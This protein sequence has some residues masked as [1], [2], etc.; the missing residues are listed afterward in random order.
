MRSLLLL[1]CF[2]SAAASAQTA[3]AQTAYVGGRWFTGDGFEA[4]DT[5]WA[6]RGTFVAGRRAGRVV[7]LGDLFVVPPF[8][9]GHLHAFESLETL[10]DED[11]LFV[12]RGVLYVLNPHVPATE[13]ASVRGLR[14]TVDV[15]YAVAGVTAPGAHPATAYEA[16]ALGLQPWD[17]WGPRGPEIRASRLRDGDA[18]TS[19]ATLADL[20]A[21]WPRVLA[22]GTDWVKVILDHSD[23]WDAGPPAQPRGLDPA[24]AAEV[25][26]RA[27]AAGLRVAAHV[28]TAADLD[29]ALDAGADLLAHVPGFSVNDA[30]PARADGGALVLSDAHLARLARVPAAPTLARGPAMVR[31]IPEASRPDA[32][33][34]DAVRAF[35]ADLLRR[36]VAAGVPLIVGADSGGLWAWDEAAYWVERG[37]APLDVLRA[38]AVTT[39][40]AIFP[41]RALGR[42]APGAEAS[43]LALA[44]DPLADWTC[45][46]RI[47][48]R[49]VQGERLP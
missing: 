22:S 28:V 19:A 32:A 17:V 48:A 6:E 21:A 5:T 12:A 49:V 43:F 30:D 23:E 7:P 18:Y 31:Y 15:T 40:Q 35:H 24:V 38:W 4:R 39:P 33:T 13:R 47:E 1:A 36:L 25:V 46:R 9:D 20:D 42:L 16:R 11:S 14:T 8:G 3:S 37:V 26:R 44:C 45:T 34:L 2:L 41:D 29:A 27:H 10:R